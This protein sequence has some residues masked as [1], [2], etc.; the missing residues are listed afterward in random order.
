MTCALILTRK[1]HAELIMFGQRLLGAALEK[2][3][4]GLDKLLL[5][6]GRDYF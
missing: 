2:I 1:S 5:R 3:A 6:S 4:Q